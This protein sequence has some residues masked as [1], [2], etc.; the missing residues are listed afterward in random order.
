M[1]NGARLERLL[2]EV[3]N[4]LDWVGLSVDTADDRTQERLGRG[5]EGYIQ[6]SIELA[7]LARAHGCRVKLNTVVTA[8]NAGQD[9]SEL[10]ARIKPERWK[11]LQVMR[12]RGQ[13]DEMPEGLE[14]D[15]ATFSSFVERHSHLESSDLVI[16]PETN[17]AMRGSYLMVDPMGRFFDS[18]GGGHTYTP[19]ILDV[20][21]ERALQRVSF[22]AAAFQERGGRYAW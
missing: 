18:A 2:G 9:L 16:V 12:V 11:I 21:V 22:D 7:E 6:R 10:V 5:A 3:G 17:D 1:T 19:K 20:G 13:N 8:W 15:A 14:V 4:L